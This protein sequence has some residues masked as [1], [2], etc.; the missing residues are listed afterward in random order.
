MEEERKLVEQ[1]FN[2]LVQGSTEWPKLSKMRESFESGK[3]IP[4]QYPLRRNTFWFWKKYG[5][6][7]ACLLLI[8]GWLGYTYLE[9]EEPA[10]SIPM[11]ENDALP[12]SNQAI[13]VLG[14]GRR[15]DVDAMGSDSLIREMGVNIQKNSDGTISYQEV[16]DD[17]PVSYNQ[18]ITPKGGMYRVSLPDGTKVKLNA[19]TSLRY[20]NRFVGGTREVELVGEAYFEVKTNPSQPFVVKSRGQEVQ[21][22]GT[23]FNITAYAED[24]KVRTTLAEGKI[25][26]KNLSTGAVKPLIPGQQAEVQ[27]GRL[28]VQ[29]ADLTQ[30]MAWLDNTFVFKGTDIRDIM[31]ELSRWYDVEVDPRNLPNET[32]YATLPRTLRL[33]QVLAALEHTSTLKFTIQGRRVTVQYR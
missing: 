6:A 7:V 27:G 21:V 31:L 29:E 33:S 16:D 14:D 25:N 12:A 24:A 26:L 22:L 8:G 2:V 30:V 32:F 23:K 15:I 13:L 3:D 28:T 19:G 5:I 20:P 9:K 1:Y 17:M 4:Q 18:I 11:V 10:A